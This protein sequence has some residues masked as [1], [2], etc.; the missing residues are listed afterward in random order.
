M[1]EIAW[2]DHTINPG[3]YGCEV[4]SPGCAHCYAATAAKQNELRG[5]RQYA[6]VSRRVSNDSVVWTGDVRIDFDRITPAFEKLPKR[7][8][9][10]IFLTSM[11]DIGHKAVPDYFRHRV[12]EEMEAR[13]HLTFQVLTKRPEVIREFIHEWQLI[14]KKDPLPN[15]WLGVSVEDQERADERIP[16]LLETP[17]VMRF[18]SVEPLLGPVDLSALPCP[19]EIDATGADH[20]NALRGLTWNGGAPPDI[21]G[22]APKID[23][24]IAGGESGPKH[25]QADVAWFEALHEQ[26]SAAGVPFFMKQDSGSRAGKQGRI[27]DG[28]WDVKEFPS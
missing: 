27:P 16:I 22:P 25:R 7:K 17:A 10:R 4:V 20:L 1:T 15:V 11:A 6:D 23:W 24:V 14:T 26:C 19:L 8:P 9:K 18:L 5:M 13:P 2:T 21:S 3:I 28:L 12:W